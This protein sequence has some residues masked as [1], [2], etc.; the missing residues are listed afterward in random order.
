MGRK[1]A[2]QG[3]D[4]GDGG[5]GPEG[6]DPSAGSMD[7]NP[8]MMGPMGMMGGMPGMAM[9]PMMGM[10]PMMMMGMNPM[11]SMMMQANM[12]NMAGMQAGMQGQPAEAASAEPEKLLDPKVKALCRDFSIEDDICAK[13]HDAMK[14]REDFDEDILALH[15]VMERATRDG[16]KPL[17]A[18]LTQIRAIKAGR[19]AGKELLDNDIWAFIEKYNLDDRVINRLVE[20]LRVRRGKKK[21]DL[22]ALDERLS[23][24]NQ[25]TGLGLLVRL[26]EG[27]EETGRL[28]SPPRRLGGSGQ[29]HPT[30]TF[31]HPKGAGGKGGRS[32][33]RGRYGGG[34]NG[35]GEGRYG[36]EDRRYGRGDSRSRSR[37]FR[38]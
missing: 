22:K 12:R 8:M 27:L 35:G 23:N 6:D 34:G 32:D 28:P 20:T 36:G 17:E 26:L 33:D 5:L 14:D 2:V 29:F 37:G 24:A 18:M 30:G 21:E 10:N 1:T 31:L 15:K 3:G 38:R 13:L 7:F 19:F 9:N 25:P 11:M 16:K 4:G